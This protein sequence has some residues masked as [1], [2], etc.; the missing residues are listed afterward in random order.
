MKRSFSSASRTRVT[1]TFPVLRPGVALS[2]AGCT[3][4]MVSVLG[5]VHVV[6]RR[7]IRVAVLLS[8]AHP[9]HPERDELV[10]DAVALGPEL[11]RK[12]NELPHVLGSGVERAPREELCRVGEALG[13]A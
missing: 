10:A 2:E 5:L 11:L 12:L 6:V 13:K 1:S 8:P 3:W 4:V 7:I 9:V